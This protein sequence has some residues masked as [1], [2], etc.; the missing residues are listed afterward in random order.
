MKPAHVL[1]VILLCGLLSLSSCSFLG[2]SS[3]SEPTPAPTGPPKADFTA[4]TTQIKGKGWVHFTSLS[5]GA[6]KEW[7]WDFNSDGNIDA[8]GP[9]AKFWVNRNGYFTTTLTVEG[10]GGERDTLT[11]PD[12][13]YAYGCNT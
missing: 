11:K 8:T 3:S 9:E 10:W 5:S 2:L 4:D 12:Y 1:F 7:Y 6:V 13:I